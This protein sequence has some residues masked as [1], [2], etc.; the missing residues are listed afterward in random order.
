MRVVFDTV[1][2]VRALINPQSRWGRIVFDHAASYT[3]ILSEPMT[4]EILTVLRRPELAKLF[5]S[6][7]SRDPATILAI[8][9]AAEAVDLADIPTINRDPKDDK[10]LATAVAGRSD[11]LVSED[12]DLL[13]M[14]RYQGIRIVD[15]EEFIGMIEE[16]QA[17]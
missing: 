4:V 8:V 13:D 7:P 12:R 17:A 10:V 3:L 11:Y 14:G 2:F 9:Q 5:N 1:G 15:A 6:L 16:E